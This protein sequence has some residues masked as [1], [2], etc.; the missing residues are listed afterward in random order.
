MTS[1]YS[2]K[3][4]PLPYFVMFMLVRL[5]LSKASFKI[6]LGCKLHY[7]WYEGYNKSFHQEFGKTHIDHGRFCCEGSKADV[8][9]V[10][11][12]F[13]L[14]T[15]TRSSKNWSHTLYLPDALWI[16]MRKKGREVFVKLCGLSYCGW[17]CRLGWCLAW[18]NF[19]Y[20]KGL[21]FTRQIFLR[22]HETSCYK[23]TYSSCQALEACWTYISEPDW[24]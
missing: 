5:A 19:K 24:E 12:K 6:Y 1:F 17:F 18:L 20:N 9:L 11:Q 2:P 10:S 8:K 7:L 15:Q 16:G 23:V 4:H 13:K 3:C 14:S 22:M 21:I